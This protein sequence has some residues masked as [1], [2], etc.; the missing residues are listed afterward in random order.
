MG[1][2]RLSK[3]K[4]L[5]D[6]DLRAQYGQTWVW[7]AIETA[8]RLIVCYLAGDRTLESCREFLTEFSSR[9]DN[10]PLFTS[11]ELPHYKTILSEIYSEEVRDCHNDPNILSRSV[12][13]CIYH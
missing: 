7:A 8:T 1:Y 9:V 5:D 13:R 2:G 3:K 10:I 12:I 11:D 4:A 6:A